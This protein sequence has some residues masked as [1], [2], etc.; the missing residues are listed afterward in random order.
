MYWLDSHSHLA[1]ESFKKDPE[2]YLERCKE[3][4]VGHLLAIACNLE[5]G[6]YC[7]KLHQQYPYIDV[8]L[9]YH[10]EDLQKYSPTDWNKLEKALQNKNIIAVGEIGLDYHWDTSYNEL[11]KECFIR[12]INYA[13][14]YDKPIIVHA[15]DAYEDTYNIL[16]QYPV[17]AGVL[18]HC[19]SGSKEMAQRYRT[20]GK[21]YFAFGGTLTY[22][23]SIKPKEAA[24]SIPLER[25]LTET[26]S[27]TLTPQIFRGQINE[28]K[29]VRYVGEFLAQLKGISEEELQAAVIKNYEELFKVKL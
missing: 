3:N 21:V 14:Q 10:P 18:M 24:L 4:N 16:S 2:G 12:Q 13:N 11:Q 25:I 5:E 28:S 15:R 8:A 26:D 23:N 29:N 9:G 17:K 7:L 27:P 20:L 6:E 19:Y 1:D 22:K